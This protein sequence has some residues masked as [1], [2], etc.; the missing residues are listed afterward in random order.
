MHASCYL[1][2]SITAI[3]IRMIFTLLYKIESVQYVLIPFYVLRFSVLFFLFL[4]SAC[5]S[6]R[7]SVH[8]IQ[9]LSR[10]FIRFLR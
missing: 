4:P 2:V 7:V 9:A 10:R 3:K 6:P 1:Q 8:L 5:R